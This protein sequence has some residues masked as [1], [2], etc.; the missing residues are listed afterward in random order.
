[1]TQD[2]N[3]DKYAK[4]AAFVSAL[5][6]DVVTLL[7]PQPD[8]RILDLGCG[9]GTLANQICELGAQVTGV[10]ASEDMVKAAQTLGINAHCISGEQLS[11]DEE[12]DA[13]FSNAALH[14]MRDYQAVVAGVYRA[15]KP[16][17]R[18]VAEFGGH[19]NVQAITDAMAAVYAKH[20]DWGTYKH[21][22]FFPTDEYYA[23]VL[24]QHG[25]QVN[26]MTSFNRPTPLETGVK[27]WLKLFA[28]HATG[29]LNETETE[30]FLTMVEAELKTTLYNEDDGWHADYVRLRFSA[31]KPTP[32]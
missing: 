31:T 24:V 20:T 5:G 6:T 23:Q 29:H 3:S 26:T 25:F 16:G 13:V 7:D 21:P 15:L 18:F 11:F 30:D 9:D 8:E 14:W 10:D 2:W 27:Q 17:G 28:H 1:M 22:W 4:D 19:G 12:F 32:D